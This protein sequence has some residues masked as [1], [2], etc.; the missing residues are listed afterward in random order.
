M[1]FLG[2]EVKG[3]SLRLRYPGW[4][5]GDCQVCDKVLAHIKICGYEK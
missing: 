3:K 4:I 2:K 5:S 1:P